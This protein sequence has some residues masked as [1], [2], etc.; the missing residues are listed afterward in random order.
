M[1]RAANT[2]RQNR[3][4][5]QRTGRRGGIG[6][7]TLRRVPMEVLRERWRLEYEQERR[8]RKAAQDAA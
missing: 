6:P 7:Y 2:Y 8:A 3:R 5:A 4:N 1:A